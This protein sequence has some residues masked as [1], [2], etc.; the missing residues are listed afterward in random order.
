LQPEGSNAVGSPTAETEAEKMLKWDCVRCGGRVTRAA[1]VGSALP[2]LL[3]D[4]EKVD[5]V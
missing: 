3:N 1:R 4:V 2:P 5:E